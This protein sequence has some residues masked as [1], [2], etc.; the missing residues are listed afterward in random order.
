MKKKLIFLS[1]FIVLLLFGGLGIFYFTQSHKSPI[2]WA[3]EAKY[4]TTL[5]ETPKDG[6]TPEDH[7][8]YDN[9]AYLFW[10]L[11]NTDTFSS[12]TV[13]SAVSV[14]QKQSIYNYRVVTPEVQMIDT[15]SIG[16]ATTGKQKY[17]IDGQKVLL[18]DFV[19][20]KGDEI[21][22][23]TDQ[24]ECITVEGYIGRYGWTPAQATAYIICQETIL[25]ISELMTV[26]KGLYQISVSLNPGEE[27]A[28]FW[29]QREVATNANA[30]DKP[31]FASIRL[32]FTFD[33][34]WVLREVHTQEKY[35]ITPGVFP[36][37][38]DCTTDITET[39]SYDSVE[40]DAESVS[41]FEQYQDLMPS[42]GE[43]V[44]KEPTALE[45]VMKALA[46][47]EDQAFSFTLS[48]KEQTLRGSLALNLADLNNI[49]LKLK[50]GNLMIQYQDQTAYI[51]FNSIKLKTTIPDLMDLLQPLFNL[52]SDKNLDLSSLNTTS[53]MN[54]FNSAEIIKEEDQISI[55]AT[56]HL[57]D[58]TVPLSFLIEETEESYVM[59]S[60]ACNLAWDDFSFSVQLDND[61]SLTFPTLE[62]DYDDLSHLGFLIDDLVEIIKNGQTEI[63][64]SGSYAGVEVNGNLFVDFSGLPAVKID[65]NLVY[66]EQNID[67]QICL[68]FLQ[69][70][71]YVDY[72]NIKV[73]LAMSDLISFLNEMGMEMPNLTLD[74]NQ[75]I[76]TLFAIDYDRLFREFDLK[77]DQIEIGLGLSSLCSA[78]QDLHVLITNQETGFHIEANYFDLKLDVHTASDQTIGIDPNQYV[79]LCFVLDSLDYLLSIIGKT[80]FDLSLNGT[81][82]VVLSGKKETISLDSVLQFVFVD[83]TYQMDA[84]VT[85][86]FFENQ[87]TVDFQYVDG[88]LYISLW[89]QTLKLK[90]ADLPVLAEEILKRLDVSL[91]SI[92]Q[93][94]E[95]WF[96][97]L[98]CI[99]MIDHGIEIDLSEVFP[100]IAVI[101]VALF[102]LQEEQ[103]GLKLTLSSDFFDLNV[104]V[105]KSDRTE[106]VAVPNRPVLD[107]QSILEIVD[108]LC[109]LLKVIENKKTEFEFSGEYQAIQV[110]GVGVLDFSDGLDLKLDLTITDTGKNK[111]E[112]IGI[113]ILNGTIYLDYR[114]IHLKITWSELEQ[115]IG[116]AV[117][118]SAS[119]LDLVSLI[120]T[121]FSFDFEKILTNLEIVDGQIDIGLDLS[122]LG[123]L[124]ETLK[125]IQLQIKDKENGFDIYINYFDLYIGLRP[126]TNAVITVQEENYVDGSFLLD[127]LDYLL[128]IIGKTSFDLSL[129]GTIEVV[130]SGKKETISLDSVLQ[131][132]FVDQTYQMDATVTVGFFENQLTVD[133]QYADGYLYLTAFEQTI[134]FPLAALPKLLEQMTDSQKRF[135]VVS[136]DTVLDAI[137]DSVTII[138]H[139]ISLSLKDLF[140]Q[141]ASLSLS[142]F[143]LEQNQLKIELVSDSFF[144]FTAMLSASNQTT[145]DLPKEN[146]L[147]LSESDILQLV[148][149][150][151][152]IITKLENSDGLSVD[153]SVNIGDLTVK[154]TVIVTKTQEI[155]LSLVLVTETQS[156]PFE[157]IYQNQKTYLKI[158]DLKMVFTAEDFAV[159][160]ETIKEMLA[161]YLPSDEDKTDVDT[162]LKDVLNSLVIHLERQEDSLELVLDV[163]QIKQALDVAITVTEDGIKLNGTVAQ[164]IAFSIGLKYEVDRLPQLD[165]NEYLAVSNL[166]ALFENL[167]TGLSSSGEFFIK[168]ASYKVVLPYTMNLRFDLIE[169]LKGVPVFEA[170]ELEL[171][172][173]STYYEPIYLRITNGFLYLDSMDTKYQ[174]ELPVYR[175]KQEWDLSTSAPQTD[176]MF[177]LIDGLLEA[178]SSI[179][180][181]SQPTKLEMV[182]ESGS[183]LSPLLDSI[184]DAL[185]N[186]LQIDFEIKTVLFAMELK[187][188][189]ADFTVSLDMCVMDMNVSMQLQAQTTALEAGKA[190]VNLSEEEKA[191]Y[192]LTTDFTDHPFA[193]RVLDLLKMVQTIASLPFAEQYDELG[194]LVGKGQKFGIDIPLQSSSSLVKSLSVSGTLG[195]YINTTSLNDLAKNI[196]LSADIDIL[197]TAILNIQIK[198]K[199]QLYYVGDGFLYLKVD[200]TIAGIA[201]DIA[202]MVIDLEA[203]IK[204]GLSSDSQTESILYLNDFLNELINGFTTTQTE[205]EVSLTL[206]SEATK[207][208]HKIWRQLVDLVHQEIDGLDLGS[209]GSILD[210]GDL[211]DS[212]DNF[213][214]D[215]NA[216][217]LKC[218]SKDGVLDR[219][220]V[221]LSGYKHN[222]YDETSL[223]ITIT[224][225]GALEIDHFDLYIESAK[226]YANVCLA[227]RTA[228]AKVD[229][230]GDF[231]YTEEYYQKAL[232]VLDYL[233]NEMIASLTEEEIAILNASYNNTSVAEAVLKYEQLKQDEQQ[234]KE[235]LATDVALVD[236]D[237]VFACYD[238]FVYFSS[239]GLVLTEEEVLTFERL[240]QSF[241]EEE[242]R[243][244]AG[245]IEAFE[246]ISQLDFENDYETALNYRNQ[247]FDLYDIYL[248]LSVSYQAVLEQFYPEQYAYLMKLTTD[249]ENAYQAYL[250]PLVHDFIGE[251]KTKEEAQ[252]AYDL[253]DMDALSKLSLIEN[254]HPL[255]DQLNAFVYKTYL[256]SFDLKINAILRQSAKSEFVATIPLLEE[257]YATFSSSFQLL[258]TADMDELHSMLEASKQLYKKEIESLNLLEEF[259][260]QSTMAYTKKILLVPSDE[261]RFYDFAS[262]VLD[263]TH[264]ALAQKAIMYYEMG[265]FIDRTS[266]GL[267]SAYYQ[268]WEIIYYSYSF[269]LKVTDEQTSKEELQQ[270]VLEL[271]T[272]VYN[273]Y[274]FET[275]RYFFKDY[276]MLKTTESVSYGSLFENASAD[277]YAGIIWQQYQNR[278]QA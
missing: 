214:M 269:I 256:E 45:Y 271:E 140:P 212:I 55:H 25:E 129:N 155:R 2:T 161:V 137:L 228:K 168:V 128:S 77:E 185:T 197:G 167:E 254:E 264:Q 88:Y 109:D 148:A 187:E 111:T 239:N 58:W 240:Y 221:T 110:A 74:V 87:L 21:T 73:Q 232:S 8:S 179:L 83:Q 226:T 198:I 69:D 217:V 54:D 206:S 34:N 231:E 235:I 56:L 158:G 180:I 207:V 97:I 92:D 12:T 157:L 184:N 171:V 26:E 250:E 208:I 182:L 7:T 44:E 19:S 275:Y 42:D 176:A 246:Q 105:S 205:N 166:V 81:I 230:L 72:R 219:L 103:S 138:D 11:E 224:A 141:L 169:L 106:Q 210:L 241:A 220:V 125:D 146:V 132:V 156:L 259:Q 28:P 199:V 36:I 195:V 270:F 46:K 24:P 90:L 233:Q 181:T 236:K 172:I 173:R 260:V 70:V 62:G 100:Q 64:F 96:R 57:G 47:Q 41:F 107:E 201:F 13:G 247:L 117:D 65:L 31:K 4:K 82:E 84:T 251:E 261:Q 202:N 237:S 59:Q 95:D 108:Y 115:L 119:A 196:M 170:L 133:F 71:L 37:A 76:N 63:G 222:T 50:T 244:Y 3:G 15:I 51:D 200:G 164:K 126:D 144:A 136:D 99:T 30:K 48:C 186:A 49:S 139:T 242:L 162:F 178:F 174:Y 130:L 22:W 131:F 9:L 153:L 209:F 16:P 35:N 278:I 113:V 53:I 20:K 91:P 272:H 75:I 29:Y 85:V 118:F 268:A 135:D 94:K 243:D 32:E 61:P 183:A 255:L 66:L 1:V 245:Q 10:Q 252:I 80:S 112:T 98:D 27:Y 204:D 68:T 123:E 263:E 273:A 175:L 60:I 52:I 266:L 149:D 154:G 160:S 194:N 223:P 276:T 238:S 143:M 122:S 145:V 190:V 262:L 5:L 114:N 189:E 253:F 159:I 151:K 257:E 188:E 203:M 40:L 104:L 18:R 86:G 116:G 78:F 192:V 120:N 267:D 33:Q 225:L 152:N 142:L 193:V 43:L 163:L 67:E 249:Y 274:T 124:F 38:V 39:F 229:E 121:L 265:Q 227:M 147:E 14:G 150:I 101:T 134:K 218:I 213:N 258:L 127:S 17:F 23:K 165:P 248:S 93:E 277:S 102:F 79:D 89:N 216:F 234:I 191:Q 177:D 211:I 6:T 215:V